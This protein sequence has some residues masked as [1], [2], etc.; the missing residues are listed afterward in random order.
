MELEHFVSRFACMYQTLDAVD[1]LQA[2]GIQ[3]D[4]VE[5]GVFRGG[6]M[7]LAK[8]Y[9]K[10]LNLPRRHYWLFDTFE[11]MSAPTAFDKK[12]SGRKATELAVKKAGNWC[13]ASLEL[14]QSN[15]EKHGVLD[16]D[17]TFVKGKVEDTL[18]DT[19]ALPEQIALLRLDTDFYESTKAELEALYPRLVPGGML[20]VDDYG[21]W[22][23][24][25]RAVDDYFGGAP[26]LSMVEGDMSARTMVKP[27]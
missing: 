11:G 27:A 19:A 26:I 8:A 21:W 16:D 25:R 18:L 14:V 7:L 4:L 2:H 23:G 1:Y 20:V 12:Y 10:A 24:A 22:D 5:C 9:A 13:R 17:V 3:G 15:F 6:H